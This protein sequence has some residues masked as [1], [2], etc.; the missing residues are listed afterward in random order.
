AMVEAIAEGAVPFSC[1]GTDTPGTIDGCRT[2]A[3]E[4]VDALSDTD[5]GRP[6]LDRLFVQV[7]GGALATAVLTGF[8]ASPAL[9][10]L[11]VVH[12]VQPRGN[13]PLVR[14]WDRLVA[15]LIEAE[16][17]TGNPDRAEAAAAVGKMGDDQARRI[18]RRLAA[19]GDRYMAP[20]DDEPESYATGILDDVTYD[21]IPIVE[22]MLRTGGHPVIAEEPDL[23]RAHALA[24]TRTDI[25]VCPTGAA[26][27]GG[28]VA[29]LGDGSVTPAAGERIVVMFTGH[30][31]AGDPVPAGAPS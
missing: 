24:R 28:L 21:W 5:D 6:R 20:W 1:Q 22:A 3:W 29:A 26:G 13:H 17:P 10:R 7:G 14:A 2:L 18:V 25:E 30:S 12:A 11:P 4:I 23:R 27:L 16:Q 19:S 8:A 9:D 15:E 31:R